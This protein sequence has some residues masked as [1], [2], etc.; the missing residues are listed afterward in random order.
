MSEEDVMLQQLQAYL[1]DTLLAQGKVA[2]DISPDAALIEEGILDSL[3][4]LDFVVL[5][6]RRCGIKIPGEDIIPE[7]FGSL[8]A[9]AT[10]LHQRFGLT[11]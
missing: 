1:R 8:E 10:Y 11:G 2:A 7:H 9:V 6:E 5:I 3:L 4:L